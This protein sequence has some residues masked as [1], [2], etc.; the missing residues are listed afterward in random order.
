MQVSIKVIMYDHS[1][2]ENID[3]YSYDQKR[4]QSKQYKWFYQ[5]ESDCH[6]KISTIRIN[7]HDII[8]NMI[9]ISYLQAYGININHG[10]IVW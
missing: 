5:I 6:Q 4:R 3:N 2:S 1:L 10:Q 8:V 7:M 9:Y